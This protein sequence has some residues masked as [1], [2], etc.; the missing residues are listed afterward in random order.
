MLI[1]DELL[2]RWNT[3]ALNNGIQ[4][5]SPTR[6][7]SIRMAGSQLNPVNG[8]DQTQTSDPAWSSR[9]TKFNKAAVW[10]AGV[11]DIAPVCVP[12]LGLCLSIVDSVKQLAILTGPESL[13][14]ADTE[15]AH[16][17]HTLHT[18]GSCG[19]LLLQ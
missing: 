15:I 7:P 11:T 3:A 6:H 12:G 4:R 9:L 18:R 19:T 13:R 16:R 8:H 14:P 17:Y 5:P 10:I 2:T 1:A